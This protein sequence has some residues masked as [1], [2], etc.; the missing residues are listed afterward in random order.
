MIYGSGRTLQMSIDIAEWE[1]HVTLSGYEIS[2]VVN[3]NV[4]FKFLA[5]LFRN[6]DQN[7]MNVCKPAV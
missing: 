6:L 4:F 5:L 3:L 1:Q 7:V 2:F